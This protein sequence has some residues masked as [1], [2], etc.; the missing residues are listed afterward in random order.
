MLPTSTKLVPVGESDTHPA[1]PEVLPP[2]ASSPSEDHRVSLTPEEFT[3][4]ETIPEHSHHSHTVP[5]E[6][7]HHSVNDHHHHSITVDTILHP[8]THHHTN[9]VETE[10]KHSEAG[11]TETGGKAHPQL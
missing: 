6:P 1:T 4:S 5:K 10:E 2:S 3:P 7:T 8:P 9:L 11:H